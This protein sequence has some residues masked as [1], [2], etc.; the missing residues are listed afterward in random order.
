MPASRPVQNSWTLADLAVV[1]GERRKLRD[2]RNSHQR[3][4]RRTCK[5][6]TGGSYFVR[7]EVFVSVDGHQPCQRVF[8]WLQDG[9]SCW[10]VAP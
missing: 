2:G 10:A 4:C 6:C 5:G 3:K 7:P 1:I 8:G 9:P